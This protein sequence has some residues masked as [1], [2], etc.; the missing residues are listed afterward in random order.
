VSLISKIRDHLAA[1]RQAALFDVDAARQ[2]WP[3]R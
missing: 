3:P 1:Q 2:S